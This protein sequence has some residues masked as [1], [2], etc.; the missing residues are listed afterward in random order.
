MAGLHQIQSN[1]YWVPGANRSQFPYSSGLY[2]KGKDLRVLIDAGMGPVNMATCLQEG[3]DLIILSHCH[4]DHRLTLSLFP[5][6]PLWCHTIEAA[7]LEKKEC[8]LEGTGLKRGGLDMEK[9]Y[10]GVVIQEFSIRRKLLDGEVLSLGGMSLQVLHTPGHTP[11]HLAFWIPEAN[12]LFSADITLTPFGPFYG[13]DFSSIEE[14]IGSIKKTSTLP[15]KV[16]IT[17]HSGPFQTHLQSRFK[18]YEEV[19]YKRDRAILQVLDSPRPFSFLLNKNLIYPA[20]FEPVSFFQWYEQVHLEKH[21]VKLEKEGK[22]AW[23]DGIFRK[24]V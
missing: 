18:A 17:G 3:I 6:L 15:A 11:G 1:L 2:L 19:I 4:L 21:L 13:H 14:Y 5:D 22:V 12:L 9:L 8:F 16:V 24:I 7:Y 10:S 23:E 20:Y